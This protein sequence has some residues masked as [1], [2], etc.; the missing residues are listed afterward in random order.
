MP[1]QFVP[2]AI[3]PEAPGS[4]GRMEIILEGA[5]I[6]VGTGLDAAALGPSK[7]LGVTSNRAGGREIAKPYSVYP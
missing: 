7:A 2:V 3:A 4:A 1:V 6:L 5:R